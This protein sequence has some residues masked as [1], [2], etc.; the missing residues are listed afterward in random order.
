MSTSA[1]QQATNHNSNEL[2]QAAI[3]KHI[4]FY[5]GVCGL[6]NK[7]IQFV[8]DNDKDGAFFFAA[9][10]SDF[11]SKTLGQRGVNAGNL[12]TVYILSNYGDDHKERLYNK[13]DAVAFSTSQLKPW[14]KPL[15]FL[16]K[17]FPKPLRDFGYET[18]AKIRYKLFGKHDQCMLPS[19]ET[20]A[21]FIEAS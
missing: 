16:I 17:I 15:A 14:I 3:G 7:F 2:Y 10:Q 5:D 13:S 6:C 21:R 1:N 8:I 9:L 18:V 19:P 20:R 11:A 4:I 12:D